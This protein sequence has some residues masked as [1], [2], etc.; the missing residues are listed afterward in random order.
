VATIEASKLLEHRL[1]DPAAALSMVERGLTLAER[2]RAIGM[3]EPALETNLVVR[4]DRLRRRLRL[5][6]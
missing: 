6:A 5:A 4:R 1:R 2:R 3:P